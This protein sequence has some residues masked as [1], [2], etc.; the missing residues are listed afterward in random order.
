MRP[1]HVFL[2]PPFHIPKSFITS[3]LPGNYIFSHDEIDDLP[4]ANATKVSPLTAL[5]ATTLAALVIT[6]IAS[7]L[8]ATPTLRH[9]I[10]QVTSDIYSL[11]SHTGGIAVPW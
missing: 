1:C 7:W 4:S 8:Q 10:L 9:G 6:V 11:L 2:N 3:S 5:S